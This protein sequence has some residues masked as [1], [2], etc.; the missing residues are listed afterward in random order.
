MRVNRGTSCADQL[1]LLRDAYLLRVHHDTVLAEGTSGPLVE[2]AD[3]MPPMSL[4]EGSRQTSLEL[5]AE[6]QQP[7]GCGGVQSE[8]YPQMAAEFHYRVPEQ[9]RSLQY[10]HFRRPEVHR[11]QLRGSLSAL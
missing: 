3:M 5:A 1:R 11:A 4:E 6:Q 7:E 10:S 8:S 2:A 9:V